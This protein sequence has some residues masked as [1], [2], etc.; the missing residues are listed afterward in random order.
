MKRF[1]ALLL[2]ALLALPLCAS[3]ARAADISAVSAVL[4][5]AATGAVL[6]EKAP[7]SKMRIAS[8]TKIMTALAVLECASVRLT[9]EVKPCHMA[10]G[11]SMYLKPGEWLTVEELLYGL[12]LSSG[13]DAALALADACGGP[14]TL[15]G[16]M[17]ELAAALGMEDTS[18][19]NPSGLDGEAHYSTAYDMA[20]LACRAI[21]DPTLRRIFS[22]K[23]AAVAGRQLRNHNKLLSRLEGCIGLKTGYT[24]AAGR[25]LVSCVE[26]EGR[27]LVAVTLC[28]GNDWA[29]HAALYQLG[30]ARKE[31]A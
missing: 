23:S 25:T 27:Q 17:N 13:N 5:D 9:V 22:T 8:T 15:V 26:R 29:D 30:F 16:K 10:E 31:S 18:F 7:H 20:L 28:D 14:E 3:T 2:A 4:M 11:S 1:F 19:E 21:E 6:Y 12:L 24:R